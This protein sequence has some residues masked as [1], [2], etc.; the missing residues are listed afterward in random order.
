MGLQVIRNNIGNRY[1]VFC[2]RENLG[3]KKLGV[4]ETGFILGA[5]AYFI[6]FM[7]VVANSISNGKMLQLA[8]STTIKFTSA[9]VIAVFFFFSYVF[10]VMT[11]QH[12]QPSFMGASVLAMICLCVFYLPLRIFLLLRPPYQ[13]L[14]FVSFVLVFA[15]MMFKLFGYL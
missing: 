14:E 10:L 8:N 5:A 12:W 9:I 15:F 3:V 13:K 1:P 2:K 6:T 11:F 7:G 4:N